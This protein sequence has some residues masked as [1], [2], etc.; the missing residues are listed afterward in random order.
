MLIERSPHITSEGSRFQF[1]LVVFSHGQSYGSAPI[2]VPP[3][4]LSR[5]GRLSN[6]K[7]S[8][9]GLTSCYLVNENGMMSI[10]SIPIEARRATV[11]ETLQELSNIGKSLAAFVGIDLARVFSNGGIVRTFR[12]GIW[13]ESPSID[14]SRLAN[15]GYPTSLLD[16][17]NKVCIKMSETSKFFFFMLQTAYEIVS[18]K[19]FRQIGFSECD[20]SSLSEGQLLAYAEMDGAMII[21]TSGKLLGIS[22]MLLFASAGT[23]GVGG[24]RHESARLYSASQDCVVFVVSSDGPVSIFRHGTLLLKFFSE[25][26]P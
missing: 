2:S 14:L 13:L 25:L 4:H 11:S 21:A 3:F 18:C 15:E 6:L 23:S 5:T 16:T 8:V 26:N 22:Q 20:L 17:V 7:N 12:K 9:D 1:S 24:A 19:P 10:V